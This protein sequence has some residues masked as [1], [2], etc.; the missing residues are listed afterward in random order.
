MS[1]ATRSALASL[2]AL[3]LSTTTRCVDRTSALHLGRT[4]RVTDDAA[5]D[6]VDVALDLSEA[7][8]R[9]GRRLWRNSETL[10]RLCEPANTCL[11]DYL[12]PRVQIEHLECK[13]V[14]QGRPVLARRP[15]PREIVLPPPRETRPP[16]REGRR[17]ASASAIRLI[18]CSRGSHGMNVTR[19]AT[20]TRLA[21]RRRR[22]ASRPRPT[23][24]R[25]HSGA[26]RNA[27]MA[28]ETPLNAFRRPA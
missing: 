10:E 18:N 2:L 24:T 28:S 20:D 5:I 8:I 12:Q 26:R 9:P 27:S 13:R 22:S 1:K 3:S 4:H 25:R 23:M 17:S 6:R 16:L 11:H 19:S 7:K 14:G 21:R 15:E